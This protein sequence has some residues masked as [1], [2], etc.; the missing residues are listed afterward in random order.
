MMIIW[1]VWFGRQ[2]TSFVGLLI[3]DFNGNLVTFLFVSLCAILF[4]NFV[5]FWNFNILAMLMRYMMY[6][7]YLDIVAF[8]IGDLVA[9]FSI[10]VARF[11]MLLVMGFTLFFLNVGCFSFILLGAMLFIYII[12]MFLIMSFAMRD[13][14]FLANRFVFM[15]VFC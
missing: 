2:I 11:A 13:F 12:A 8:L 15:F 1:V 3:W 9:F 4:W 6:F 5:A 7:G 14:N 10:I